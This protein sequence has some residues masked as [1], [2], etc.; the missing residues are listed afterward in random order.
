MEWTKK[1]P[2][3]F[4]QLYEKTCSVGSEPSAVLQQ[5]TQAWRLGG[6]SHSDGDSYWRM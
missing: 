2:L 6:D 3:D 5:I 1:N 4:I